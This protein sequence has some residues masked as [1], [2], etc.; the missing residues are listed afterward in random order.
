MY[1]WYILHILGMKAGADLRVH[2]V[3][4]EGLIPKGRLKSAINL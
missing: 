4:A 1:V 3:L 2:S